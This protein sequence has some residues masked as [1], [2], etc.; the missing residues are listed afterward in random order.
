MKLI[1]NDDTTVSLESFD[2]ETQL[3]ID[4][5]L[6]T[7]DEQLDVMDIV[8][9]QGDELID[10]ID[11]AIANIETFGPTAAAFDLLDEDGDLRAL[12]QLD[13]LPE[14]TD[15]NKDE[16]ATA[17]LEG[18]KDSAAAAWNKIVEFFKMIGRKIKDM[19]GWLFNAMSGLEKKCENEIKRLKAIDK[20]NNFG[21]EKI[22]Y[23]GKNV[24]KDIAAAADVLSKSETAFDKAMN[25]DGFSV[26]NQ[27]VTD[28]KGMLLRVAPGDT[29]ETTVA[30]VGIKSVADA[31]GAVEDTKKMLQ[32]IKP[33]QKSIKEVDKAVKE[34]IKQAN[35]AMKSSAGTKEEQAT[36]KEN[37]KLKQKKATEVTKML[38][39]NA[40]VVRNLAKRVLGITKKIKEA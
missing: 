18:L 9:P 26:L 11:S 8:L 15:E 40:K 13:E 7:L 24:A 16:I 2:G 4:E 14:I 31:I 22:M 10:N 28:A 35:E 23:P 38:L 20:P 36:R 33:F 12:L 25:A 34:G 19:V 32:G 5:M 3:R 29:E 27:V 37:V 1:C 17:T 6:V 21:D 30:A 39:G